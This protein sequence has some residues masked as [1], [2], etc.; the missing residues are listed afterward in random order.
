[1]GAVRLLAGLCFA[2]AIQLSAA[3]P[4]GGTL[5]APA[6]AG[7]SSTVTWSGGPYSGATA[8]PSLCTTLTCDS[9]GLNVNVPAAFYSSNPSYSIQIGIN[10]A[11]STNDFDLY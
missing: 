5:N 4:T 2:I 9:Y 7:Q 6:S 3:T 11:S 1:M 10:W 8:D